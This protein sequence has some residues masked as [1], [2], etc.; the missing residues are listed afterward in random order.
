MDDDVAAACEHLQKA[1]DVGLKALINDA[2]R[3]GLN[4]MSSPPKRPE[5]HA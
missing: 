3:R 4:E 2:L 1:R 5:P